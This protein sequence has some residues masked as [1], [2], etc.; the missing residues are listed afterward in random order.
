MSFGFRSPALALWLVFFA[1][2]ALA[3]QTVPAKLT[4]EEA[5]AIARE[6][7]PTYRQAVNDLNTAS[8]DL[9][10]GWGSF[11]PG[12]SASLGFGASNFRVVTGEDD[13][14]QPRMLPEPREFQSS[15]A[16]QSIGAS[17]VLFD[18]LRTFH[19]LRSAKA[20][21][22]A[23]EAKRVNQLN[24]L[25]A[26][27]TRRFYQAVAASRLVEL[28]ERL[29]AAARE[30]LT[31]T[32]RLFNLAGAQQEDV[33]G[34][35]ID[36]ANQELAIER[37]RA[38]RIK[39]LLALKEQL[40][41]TED[42]SF[43]VEGE[44]PQPVDPERLDAE[45]LVARALSASPRVVELERSRDAARAS[46]AAQSGQR[47]PTIRASAG[48]SRSMSLSSYEALFQF[49]PRNRG[50]SF[51][52]SLEFPLFTQ[53]RTTAAVTRA[54]VQAR[55]AEESVRAGRLLVE[56]EVRSALVD[57][58]NAYRAVELA[59]RTA[60][61]S[62]QRVRLATERYR[63]GQMTF[64]NLQQ[65]IAQAAQSERQVLQARLDAAIARVTLEEKVGAPLPF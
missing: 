59:E 52:F 34:A 17:L 45:A 37:A 26:E 60:E 46:A 13:F 57:L 12:V 44:L 36:V 5:L 47:W 6:R 4:L 29:L 33:L 55:N 54:E 63:I 50:F 28:E 53:F 39:S 58:K 32:E 7:N 56:R 9:R 62:R 38:Q 1:P 49:N 43:E 41:I 16:S 15:S 22:A 2:A 25:E 10:A 3:A 8:A 35:Q 48:I 42:I 40:G 20:A 61:L 65:I 21:A 27:T 51:G 31:F 24:A 14:G 19:T 18:G 11:L 64:T 23:A 30:Q